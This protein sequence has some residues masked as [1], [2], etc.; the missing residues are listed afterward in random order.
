MR[1]VEDYIRKLEQENAD[2]CQQVYDLQMRLIDAEYVNAVH[3]LHLELA[4]DQNNGY[5]GTRR[6]KPGR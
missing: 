3:K 5:G 2:L 1:K 6:P 4:A